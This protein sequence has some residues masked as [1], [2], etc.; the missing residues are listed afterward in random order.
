MVKVKRVRA[1]EIPLTRF[2]IFLFT[3]LVAAALYYEFGGPVPY[4]IYFDGPV[5]AAFEGQVAA[6]EDTSAGL[7]E[8]AETFRATYPHTV[9][10]WG[11]RWQ[12]VIANSSEGGSVNALYTISVR[13]AG[14]I[15]SEAYRWGTETNVVCEPQ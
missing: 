2:F 15:C 14:V 9:T 13:R 4:F 7:P 5:G 6:L 1:P 8:D 11:P 12:G 3:L 10:L